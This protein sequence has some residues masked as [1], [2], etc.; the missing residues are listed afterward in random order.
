MNSFSFCKKSNSGNQLKLSNKLKRKDKSNGKLQIHLHSTNKLQKTRDSIIKKKEGRFQY[1]SSSTIHRNKQISQSLHKT[2]SSLEN[3]PIRLAMKW[4]EAILTSANT[5]KI[6]KKTLAKRK[7]RTEESPPQEERYSALHS[8]KS[9]RKTISDFYDTSKIRA[10]AKES[11]S[12]LKEIGQCISKLSSSYFLRIPAQDI[13]VEEDQTNKR[14]KAALRKT[15]DE[16]KC[17]RIAAMY[18]KQ[19]FNNLKSQLAQKPPTQLS[20]QMSDS[21]IMGR[22]KENGS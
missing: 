21:D 6:L 22:V 2:N 11:T 15:K 19:K 7:I 17:A 12:F 1:F 20:T 9:L 16:L 14:L 3:P 5:S 13:T 18:W 8:V 4:K 10:V